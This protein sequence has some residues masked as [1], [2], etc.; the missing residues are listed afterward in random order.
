MRV[1][2]S[3]LLHHTEDQELIVECRH[4][5]ERDK[6]GEEKSCT[7]DTDWEQHYVLYCLELR[8]RILYHVAF[9]SLS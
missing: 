3:F 6:Y 8:L 5:Q 4:L 9:N 1:P 7:Q 2:G